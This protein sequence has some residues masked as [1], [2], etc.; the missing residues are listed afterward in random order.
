MQPE[1]D[2]VSIAILQSSVDLLILNISFFVAY[3]IKIPVS[4]IVHFGDHYLFLLVFFN[5]IWVLIT[6]GLKTYE[7]PGFLGMESIWKKSFQTILLHLAVIIVFI[8]IVKGFYYS[9]GL[10]GLAYFFLV[11]G[12][13]VWRTFFIYL[14][15]RNR[16]SGHNL[17]RVI[18]VGSGTIGNQL[19][20]YFTSSLSL[21][22]KFEGFF[23]N[24]PEQCMPVTMVKGSLKDV[25]HY[26]NENPIDEIFCTFRL[27]QSR[28]IRWLRDLADNHLIRFKLVPDFKGF[29]NR[30]VSLNYYYDTPVLTFR[31]EP[32]ERT[33]NSIVKRL[34]DVIFS[35][36]VIIL[37]S[38][39][40]LIITLLIKVSSPGSV[41]FAQKRSG[42]NKEIFTCYKFRSMVINEVSDKHQAKPNDPRVTPIGKFLRKTNLDEL[43]QFFNVLKGEMSVVG[44]RPH[45]LAHTQEY[46]KLI[47]RFHVRHFVKPGITGW[48]Q[49]N[50]LRGPLSKRN[51]YMRVR[52]DVWYVENWS[53]LLDIKIILRTILNMFAGERNAF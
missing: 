3:A 20:N 7:L 41:L 51:M 42:R 10:V 17:K 24:H 43:P 13:T 12:I 9:R 28:S 40:G 26:I 52:F 8:F 25:E 36:L 23:H 14:V 39:L 46:A 16:K 37:L 50:G 45:M 4:P 22:Y 15:K 47:N 33:V 18:I 32:L 21:G 1:D 11:I 38:P 2:K 30:N 6:L 49:V 35:S 53:L 31:K 44:P 34:F 19:Y 5:L 48:A 27:N 29:L